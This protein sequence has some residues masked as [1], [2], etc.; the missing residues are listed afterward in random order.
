MAIE[1]YFS[2]QL[3][4]LADKFV[5]LVDLEN[6]TKKNVLESTLTIV[7]NQNLIKWLQLTIAKRRSV[8]MNL[9]FQYLESGL[10]DLLERLDSREGKPEMIDNSFLRML[11]LYELQT[12][13]AHEFS[14]VI[15]LI[16]PLD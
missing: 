10:W 14:I 8:F 5:A 1:L 3:E 9:D 13:S 11:L 15:H 16:S 7:P 12:L 6:Q 4:E 2:N